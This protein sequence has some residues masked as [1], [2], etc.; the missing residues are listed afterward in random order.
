MI[1]P[2]DKE[3]IGSVRKSRFQAVRVSLGEWH[4][5]GYI[6]LHTLQHL[7]GRPDSEAEERP[8]GFTLEPG[9]WRSLLPLI[10]QACE[11][12]DKQGREPVPE[13]RRQSRRDEGRASRVRIRGDWETIP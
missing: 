9:V 6:Y 3:V 5:R 11:L 4:G 1:E 7:D 12:S 10:E 13:E 8:G 2:A